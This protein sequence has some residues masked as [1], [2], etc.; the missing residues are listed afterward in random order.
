M[1]NEPIKLILRNNDQI[2][3]KNY[4]QLKD[5][6]ENSIWIDNYIINGIFL[7]ITTLDEELIQIYGKI[8]EIKIIK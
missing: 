8:K 4:H 7:K 6:T 5:I 1:L 3:I 2:I